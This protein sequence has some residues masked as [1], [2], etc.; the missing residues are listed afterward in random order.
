MQRSR[1]KG[2]S[3]I[4]QHNVDQSLD[5]DDVEDDDSEYTNVGIERSNGGI[6][7]AP[8]KAKLNNNITNS[9]RVRAPPAHP[10]PIRGKKDNSKSE[11]GKI[12]TFVNLNDIPDGL[13]D[14]PKRGGIVGGGG[15]VSNGVSYGQP[16]SI[17][18][19]QLTQYHHQQPQQYNNDKIPAFEP[20]QPSPNSLYKVTA[21]PLPSEGSYNVG[22]NMS[23]RIVPKLSQMRPMQMDN[24][25]PS[26][27][28]NNSNG[29]M[30]ARSNNSGHDSNSNKIIANSNYD[31]D[32]Y[33]IS[34]H[35][36]VDHGFS[37][38]NSSRNNSDDYDYDDDY[39]KN[40]F[41]TNRHSNRNSK[42][43]K[44]NS[45]NVNSSK[46]ES[47]SDDYTS[48]DDDDE[49]LDEYYVGG[50]D[51]FFDNDRPSSS[52]SY[53][54]TPEKNK[55]GITKSKNT[56]IKTDNTSSKNIKSTR[57]AGGAGAINSNNKVKSTVYEERSRKPIQPS[58]N[59]SVSSNNNNIKVYPK[60]VPPALPIESMSDV[61]NSQGKEYRGK[62]KLYFSKAPRQVDYK[63]GTLNSY[64]ASK[65][66]EY[67]E[68]KKSKPD[69][70]TDELKA[71]RANAARV[72]EFSKKL[73]EYN[74]QALREQRKLPSSKEMSAMSI[75]KSKYESK[76]EKMLEFARQI[77]K[78]KPKAVNE[79]E[80]FEHGYMTRE[81]EFGMS[82]EA[83][84]RMQELEAK[85]AQSQARVEAI[86][87]ALKKSNK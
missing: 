87:R 71:K 53:S 56:H 34:S 60:Y 11:V 26:P 50:D 70:N 48:W 8:P 20:M 36:D 6:G 1:P 64:V 63:P 33:Q 74:K 4:P 15:G 62:D 58:G 69:L 2:R 73:T 84:M 79:N 81:D 52:H 42:K 85:H 61:S 3:Y 83:A 44:V 78:P 37:A 65:P 47:N 25:E 31:D 41:N 19:P 76:R 10:K 68:I 82:H 22:V 72:K 18:N 77:P 28:D 9:I 17:H 66:K 35:E 24:Y 67:V 39:I 30:S 27:I 57:V 40:N 46:S 7:R 32:A 29:S 12:A 51:P 5:Y 43:N 75:A 45:K 21:P 49:G 59:G 13:P 55:R 80:E 16:K 86:K 23:R 14:S 54:W 38:P